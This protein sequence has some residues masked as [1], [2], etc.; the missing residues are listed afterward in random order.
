M[1]GAAILEALAV[2]TVRVAA[3]VALA[4]AASWLLRHHRARI[5]AGIWSFAALACLLLPVL[6]LLVPS[7]PVH[8]Q[9]TPGFPEPVVDTSSPPIRDAGV[10]R[11]R[12][13][14]PAIERRASGGDPGNLPWAAMGVAVWL[15]LA[16]FL[17]LRDV[18]SVLHV[19]RCSGNASRVAPDAG[20]RRLERVA[21]RT[22]ARVRLAAT[23][24]LP[25]PSTHGWRRPTILVPTSCVTWLGERWDA[26]LTHEMAHVRFADWALR[27]TARLVAA[28][29]WF[30][31]LA[32]ILVASLV[33][34]QERAAD[35][36]V[37]ESGAR[38]SDYAAHLV[39]LAHRREPTMK[40]AEAVAAMAAPRR[41][42]DRIVRILNHAPRRSL[43]PVV[44]IPGVICC[45]ALTSVLAALD[46]T[47]E[48]QVVRASEDL[49]QT[50]LEIQETER[51]YQPQIE[52]MERAAQAI[53]AQAE[54]I[55]AEALVHEETT[56]AVE[57]VMAR[58][59]ERIAEM[60]AEMA[61]ILERIEAKHLEMSGI[62]EAMEAMEALIEP[63]EGE[64]EAIGDRI[65]PLAEELARVHLEKRNEARQLELETQIDMIHES[66]EP[67][68]EQINEVVASM[69]PELERLAAV[70]AL[71][72]PE[73]EAIEEI[74][75]RYAEDLEALADIDVEIDQEAMERLHETMEPLLAEIDVHDVDMDNLHRRM[76]GLM[77]QLKP[78]LSREIERR[79][80]IHLGRLANGAAPFREVAETL[81][82]DA[83]IIVDDTGLEFSRRRTDTES[84]LREGFF[85]G[86]RSSADLDEAIEAA[87]DAV[88][89]FRLEV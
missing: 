84:L 45:L 79:L 40:G 5:R 52:A 65:E 20:R 23:D 44:L 66:M 61:P 73:M 39:A 10:V 77:E 47:D 31:P 24:A 43:R 55:E 2:H 35:E 82:D 41:M 32:W 58:H 59:E 54:K 30:N 22:A 12:Q 17:A 80:K 49:R 57:A 36:A 1:T 63:L 51:R 13:P 25:A 7:V 37:L 26:V 69:E 33:R 72:E 38:A 87:L 48:P 75:E 70:E 27:L 74:Q 53:E 15:G 3:V 89:S 8:L 88:C 11:T 34:E 86:R 78:Q 18:G 6:H 46:P 60:E 28:L 67:I 42:E 4:I 9:T 16:G 14:D 50:I 19:E 68:L 81:V 76:D 56:A 85:D 21:G 29:N 64:L 62:N 83:T 71:I